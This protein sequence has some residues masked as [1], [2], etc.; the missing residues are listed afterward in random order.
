MTDLIMQA[1]ANF[2]CLPPRTQFLVAVVAV[3]DV[4][5]WVGLG[6]ALCAVLA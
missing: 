1:R 3:I 4:M 2:R 5:L 6:V